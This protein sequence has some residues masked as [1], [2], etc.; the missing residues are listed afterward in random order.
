MEQKIKITKQL[1]KSYLKRLREIPILEYELKQ[2]LTTDAGIGNSTINDYQ[3]GFPR[4]QSIVGF[5]RERYERRKAAIIMKKEKVKAIKE[6]VDSIE[7]GQTRCIFRMKYIEGMSWEKIAMNTGYT[8][9]PD[10]PRIMICEKYLKEMEI[11]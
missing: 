8:K 7:D 9:S 3:T 10:Y 1:L 2:M 4:P 5:D 11:I 6:W